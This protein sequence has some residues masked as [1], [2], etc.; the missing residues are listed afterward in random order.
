MSGTDANE[1]LKQINAPME[2]KDKWWNR[3][4]WIFALIPLLGGGVAGAGATYLLTQYSQR[5]QVL[6]YYCRAQ[7]GIIAK[8]DIGA[9]NLKIIIDDKPVENISTVSI[10]FLN[11]S[12]IDFEDVPCIVSF[13]S[14]NGKQPLLIASVPRT[15]QINFTEFKPPPGR[16]ASLD[17]GYNI[18]VVNR[19]EEPFF[20][21]DYTFEGAVAPA[22]EVSVNKKGVQISSAD[23]SN[24][25]KAD[26]AWLGLAS[27]AAVAAIGLMIGAALASIRHFIHFSTDKT[28][29]LIASFAGN[30]QWAI[31]SPVQ[32]GEFVMVSNIPATTY[33][34][35]KQFLA[36]RNQKYRI[37]TSH[38]H[39][40]DA[41]YTILFD[42]IDKRH[43]TELIAGFLQEWRDKLSHENET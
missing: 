25:S 17:F 36:R 16:D 43:V 2:P 27:G 11:G 32:M 31:L 33:E 9:R 22:A 8:P 29:K 4:R 37:G 21:V 3:F 18:Q 42:D 13:K 38:G 28:E 40:V 15:P 12:D 35:F 5:I 26:I 10:S 19:S 24:T 41:H 20:Q 1:E 6:T 14:A 7:S 34:S 23:Q 30:L 39:G